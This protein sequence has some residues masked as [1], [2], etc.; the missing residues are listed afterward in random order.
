MISE[1]YR[2]KQTSL[3][4]SPLLLDED[5]KINMDGRA[6]ALDNIFVERLWRTVKYENIYINNYQS[7]PE[8]QF[9][10]NQYFEF[11]NQQRLSSK[12]ELSDTH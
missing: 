7:M 10:L 8:M 5:I 3:A 12:F 4:F 11:Y 1:N 9:G 6:H 2:V